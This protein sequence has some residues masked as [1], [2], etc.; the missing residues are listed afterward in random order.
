MSLFSN[1]VV[2]YDPWLIAHY[3]IVTGKH[4]RFA[5]ASS[6]FS[7]SDQA[8]FNSNS[9]FFALDCEFSVGICLGFL[10]LGVNPLGEL[11]Y[12]R[13]LPPSVYSC[14]LLLRNP[15]SSSWN[16]VMQLTIFLAHF[17]HTD[18]RLAAATLI[19][20]PTLLTNSDRTMLSAVQKLFTVNSL[21]FVGLNRGTELP[22][23]PDN[24]VSQR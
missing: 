15:A 5:T 14:E 23:Q 19:F 4:I 20:I 7:L 24:W 12:N 13:L 21:F 17:L 18:G 16:K 6:T 9:V 11:L 2:F 22:K 10:E 1:T 3:V 8:E